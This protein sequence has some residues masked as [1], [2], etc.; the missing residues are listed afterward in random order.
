MTALLREAGTDYLIHAVDGTDRTEYIGQYIADALTLYPN[1]P[2]E[3]DGDF[4]VKATALLMVRAENMDE[5]MA[6]TWAKEQFDRQGVETL[7]INAIDH[8]DFYI[9][10]INEWEAEED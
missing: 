10:V 5:V 1:D 3:P 6:E 9:H 8:T 4:I 2:N 7:L